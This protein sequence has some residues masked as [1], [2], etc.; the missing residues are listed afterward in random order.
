MEVPAD[1][2]RKELLNVLK[3][4]APLGGDREVRL[5]TYCDCLVG[6]L[7]DFLAASGRTSAEV[8]GLTAV[9]HQRLTA[10]MANAAMSKRDGVAGHA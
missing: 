5:N 8:D 10:A 7:A 9:F 1:E 2:L 6:L 3:E 4:L